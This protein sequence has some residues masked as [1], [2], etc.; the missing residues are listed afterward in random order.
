MTVILNTERAR[1][2]DMPVYASR[3]ARDKN[4]V[5]VFNPVFRVTHPLPRMV[6]L[7]DFTGTLDP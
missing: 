6:Q 5:Q 4:M 3:S 7:I 2:E 1:F